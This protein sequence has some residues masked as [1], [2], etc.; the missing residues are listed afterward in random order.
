MA[1]GKRIVSKEV[2]GF[3]RR[4]KKNNDVHAARLL[5]DHLV[6][7]QAPLAKTINNYRIK[8]DQLVAYWES[9]SSYRLKISP[10][11]RIRRCE[12]WFIRRILRAFG[13]YTTSTGS[14]QSID[15]TIRNHIETVRMYL[16]R[17]SRLETAIGKRVKRIAKLDKPGQ[18]AEKWFGQFVSREK[19]MP[20]EILQLKHRGM[21]GMIIGRVGK[22]PY[23]YKIVWLPEE[24]AL[25]EKSQESPGEVTAPPE[26]RGSG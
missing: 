12:R 21:R 20:G 2:A 7:N 1:K 6:E 9:A 14:S 22:A 19:L 10:S 24:L 18:G 8:Y 17:V 11:E 4:I 23:L 26:I 13:S 3:L 25:L 16:T 5:S 15:R